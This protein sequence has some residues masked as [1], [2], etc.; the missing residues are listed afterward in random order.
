MLL[1]VIPVTAKQVDLPG[2]FGLAWTGNDF[3][4]YNFV[5]GTLKFIF[6]I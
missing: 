3:F 6:Q 4:S 1:F 2:D 5:F